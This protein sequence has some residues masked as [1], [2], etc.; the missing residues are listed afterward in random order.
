M[1]SI[2]VHLTLAHA[3]AKALGVTDLPQFYLGN[4][5]PDAV[6]VSGF[7]PAEERYAAHLRSRSYSEWKRQISAYRAAHAEEYALCPD[8]LTGVLLHLY[9]DIAWDEAVQPQLFDHLRGRGFKE[10]EL[11][12]RKW[13]ELRGF[14]SLLAEKQPYREAVTALTHA[15]PHAVTTVTAD[16]LALW[17][18]KI[19][20]LDYPY[21]APQFLT[22]AHIQL[23]LIRAL[24]LYNKSSS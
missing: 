8:F 17:R 2:A 22:E 24:E 21:P 20:N 9:T 4:I 19:V 6:N 15:E 3:A 1:P 5:A 12:P 11:N 13:D 23:A 7:A 14:D 10:E 18:D 16:Q